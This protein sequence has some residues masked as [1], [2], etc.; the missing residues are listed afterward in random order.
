MSEHD[1]SERYERQATPVPPGRIRSSPGL[2]VGIALVGLVSVLVGGSVV[3]GAASP[4]PADHQRP[5]VDASASPSAATDDHHGGSRL[6][7]LDKLRAF[8]RLWKRGGFGW[9]GALGRFGHFGGDGFGHHAFGK[10]SIAAINGNSISLKTDDGWTRT[11]QVTAETKIF[12]GTEAATIGDLK[13]GDTVVLRQMRN[14]DGTF[15]ITALAVPAPHAFGQVTKVDADTITIAAL[16]GTTKT[17][18][19]TAS[20]TYHLGHGDGSKADVK[21][22]S[23]IAVEGDVDATDFTATTVWIVIP[24]VFGEVTAKTDST[25]TVER[26][27]GTTITLH[28]SSSTSFRVRG[29]GDTATLA[30]VEV[31]SRIEAEGPLRADGSMDASI[32]H[33]GRIKAAQPQASPA[34]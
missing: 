9:F 34:G 13:V 33:T 2:R 19:V 31:G 30:D 28:V 14:D 1:Q 7:K 29:K 16:D 3:L 32:V 4:A 23:R 12:R 25:I 8:G 10:I 15:T 27:D 11:I 22:G 21:V 5:I 26:R 17:I 24:H 20:T 18:R 6:D